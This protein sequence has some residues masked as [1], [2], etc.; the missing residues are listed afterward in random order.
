M[1][2]E[3]LLRGG[4]CLVRTVLVTSP[5]NKTMGYIG[6]TLSVY[7]SVS[8]FTSC[9]GQNFLLLCPIWKFHTIVVYDQ[10]VC[11]DLDQRSYLQGQGYSV[12]IPKIRVRATT[13]CHVGSGEYNCFPSPKACHDLDPRSY[14]YLQNNVSAQIPKIRVRGLTPYWQSGS[15]WYF[16]QFLSIPQGCVMTLT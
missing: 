10:R 11:Y 2:L 3:W 16:T 6:I 1:T 8:L 5:P 4:G 7:L 13:H 15:G 12:L 9:P 14:M